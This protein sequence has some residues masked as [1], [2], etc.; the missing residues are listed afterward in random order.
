MC[1]SGFSVSQNFYRICIRIRFIALWVF[2]SGH[3]HMYLLHHNN[4]PWHN[5]LCHLCLILL[6]FL[7]SLPW[8]FFFLV[9]SNLVPIKLKEIKNKPKSVSLL[10]LPKKSESI[11]IGRPCVR[12]Y[13]FCLFM[14]GDYE[15]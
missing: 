6:L 8:V 2:G 15:T 12:V 5:K 1:V 14:N 3:I 4:E 9:F 11:L 7:A 10:W 13:F